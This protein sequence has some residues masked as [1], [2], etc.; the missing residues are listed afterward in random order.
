MKKSGLIVVLVISVL[1]TWAL[2]TGGGLEPARAEA[3]EVHKAA[4]IYVGPIGDLGWTWEHD[5]GRKM[6]EAEFG[7]KVE[8]PTSRACPK[9]LMRRGLFVSMRSR[10]IK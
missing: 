10:G 7:D 8:T 1:F 6:L 9:G 4:F 3:T 2:F 5:R